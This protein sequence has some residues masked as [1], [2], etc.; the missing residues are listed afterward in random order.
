MVK[1]KGRLVVSGT[2]VC[3]IPSQTM[4]KTKRKANRKA[5]SLGIIYLTSLMVVTTSLG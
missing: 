2:L 4:G 3:R 1:G 5:E